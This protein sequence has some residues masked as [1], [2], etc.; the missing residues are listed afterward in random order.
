MTTVKAYG[1]HY[2]SDVGYKP[3]GKYATLNKAFLSLQAEV[4]KIE[5]N[6]IHCFPDHPPDSS[7]YFLVSSMSPIED[8]PWFMESHFRRKF[9]RD[10]KHSESLNPLQNHVKLATTYG[11]H[12]ASETKKKKS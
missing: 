7:M 5:P 12:L 11:P 6:S 9:T 8:A 4:W 1:V 10:Y 2:S 3:K